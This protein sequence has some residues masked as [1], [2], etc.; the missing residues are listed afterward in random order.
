MLE[1][2]TN[3]SEAA[4][5]I[6]VVGVG[7]GGNNAVNRMIDE[8][9]AGVEFIAI[10]TDKQALQLCKAP[11][12]MQIGDKIT[13]GLGA[14]AR[15]EVGEKAAEE[16][17]EEISA[18]LKGADMVFVT[19]GMGGGT[20][21]G[22]TPVVARIAKEQGALTVGVVTKPFRFESKTRMSNALGGIEKLKES[23]D[24]L[25]VIPNDK[26]LEIVD[27]RTTMPEALKK[28]DEV[29]QQGI[30]GITDLINVPSLINLDFADVQT[31]MTDKG[32]AHIG[33]GQGRGDDKA[34][35]AVKQAVASPLLETTIAGASHV[36]I[37]VSGDITLMD[38]SDAAEFVQDL[39]GEEANI[40]FGAMYDDSRADEATI[41]VIA[42][43][44]HNVEGSA[45]KLKSRLENRTTQAGTVYNREYERERVSQPV[46]TQS[47]IQQHAKSSQKLDAGMASAKSSAS[48]SGQQ[49]RRAMG[50]TAPTLETPRTPT[51]KVKEQSIK[52][53]DFFKK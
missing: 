29:L 16:S 42:T 20:G 10:N 9:I 15:P 47:H 14:G 30:Q 7:G 11:T 36:I 40:I 50:G 17:A 34:L 5:K 1:I 37:N 27:R 48:A 13:K 52:I 22:A 49:V 8:Q 44:L 43:G 32:I 2:K 18:A 46:R 24:T 21:T 38:A 6:I 25:I 19:C 3:E 12:L 35:E 26:L 41:T 23:V 51:S 28:A 4:A 31:V 45:S 33:I 53:P 39:A